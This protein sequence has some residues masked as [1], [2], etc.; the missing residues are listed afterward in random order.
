MLLYVK[1][2]KVSFKI[3]RDS[4]VKSNGVRWKY[5]HELLC[6]FAGCPHKIYRDLYTKLVRNCL[7]NLP[8]ITCS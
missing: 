3:Y 6:R 2:K 1:D 8:E 4:Y 5:V 7:Q